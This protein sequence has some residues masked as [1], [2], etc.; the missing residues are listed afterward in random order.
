MP[1]GGI[2]TMAGI[3]LVFLTFA[4]ALIFLQYYFN[5]SVRTAPR[6]RPR[7]VRGAAS[8]GV[9]PELLRALPVTV[10]RAGAKGLHGRRRG[11]VRGVPDRARGRGG[12]QGHRRQ[13][14]CVAG[15]YTDES[16]FLAAGAGELRREPAGECTA[17]GFRPGH[18]R[19][20][21]RDLS[22]RPLEPLRPCHR[23]SAGDRHSGLKNSGAPAR[24]VQISGLGEAEVFE[25][26]VELREARTVGVDS[27]LLRRQR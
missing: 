9:D 21:D 14:R 23:G 12:G 17:R 7:G 20:G 11:G 4:L 1:I 10:Y 25:E 2:L 19:R 15:A 26:A 18:A 27:S 22:R 24:R 8:G 16:P 3:F 13:A 6:G 5:T